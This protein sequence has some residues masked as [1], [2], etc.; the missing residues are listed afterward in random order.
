[1]KRLICSHRVWYQPRILQVVADRQ[2]DICQIGDRIIRVR[3]AARVLA[4][5][6]LGVE[7]NATLHDT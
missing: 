2:K 3:I 4:R 5:A 1:V 6:A 7:V